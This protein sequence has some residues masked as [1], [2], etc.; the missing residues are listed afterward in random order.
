MRP[1]SASTVRLVVGVTIL[2]S[3]F[4]FTDNAVNVDT[5]PKASWQP[6]WF[7]VVV[8]VAWVLYT[9]VGVAAVWLYRRERFRA[10]HVG[11]IIYGYLVLSSLGH[12]LYGSPSELTTRG[13]VSVFVDVAAGSVVVGLALWSIL[14][15]RS[16]PTTE[17][18]R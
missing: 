15:R 17:V 9:A 18:S 3:L 5:Y 8:V 4:H 16:H 12:F 2:L 6:D 13:V 14:T 10:A 1:P 7:D 11:L